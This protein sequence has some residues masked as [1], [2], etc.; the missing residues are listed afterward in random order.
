MWLKIM[1]KKGPMLEHRIRVNQLPLSEKQFKDVLVGWVDSIPFSQKG[2]L[3]RVL[4]ES[5]KI[6][7]K[8]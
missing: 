2:P 5:F 6:E 1:G 7:S 4:T 8:G 3:I